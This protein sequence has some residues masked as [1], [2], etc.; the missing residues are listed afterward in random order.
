MNWCNFLGHEYGFSNAIVSCL[1]ALEALKSQ[2][3]LGFC[4]PE[5]PPGLYHIS[6]AA[7]MIALQ[8]LFLL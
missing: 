6:Q 2:K 1:I 8:L 7:I 5:I 4:P 3:Y